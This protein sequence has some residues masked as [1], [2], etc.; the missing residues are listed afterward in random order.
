M[1]E[2]PEASQHR[3]YAEGKRFG[4]AAARARIFQQAVGG[5]LGESM[6]RREHAEC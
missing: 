6:P 4:V 1:L 2:N 5:R 3:E